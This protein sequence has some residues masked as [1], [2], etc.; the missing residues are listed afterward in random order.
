MYP[1]FLVILGEA[2]LLGLGVVGYDQLEFEAGVM[3]G[4]DQRVERERKE[5]ERKRAT[6]ELREVAGA[7][8]QAR[9]QLAQLQRRIT[10]LLSRPISNVVSELKEKKA[11]RAKEVREVHVHTHIYVLCTCTFC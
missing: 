4:L 5:E 9:I 11:I 2:G 1:L 6:R 3:R 10:A 7:M 8:R